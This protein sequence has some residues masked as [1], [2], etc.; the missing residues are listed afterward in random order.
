[1]ERNFRTKSGEI[2]IVA[3]DGNTLCFVEVKT[4]TSDR[5]GS[6]GES[7]DEQKMRTIAEL[8]DEYSLQKGTHEGNSRFDIVEVLFRPGKPREIALIKNVWSLDA[9][10]GHFC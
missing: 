7:V 1:M 5:F 3:L 10:G 6:P 8:A 4:R 9:D 2:D